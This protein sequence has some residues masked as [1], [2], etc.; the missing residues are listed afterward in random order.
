MGLRELIINNRFLKDVLT[1]LS[2]SAIAQI[3]GF[4]LMPVLT[5][6]FTPEEFGIFYIFLTTASILSVLITG[7]YE[8]SLVL[9]PSDIDAR[10]LLSFVFMLS[11]LST[12]L[13]LIILLFLQDWGSVFFQTSHSKLILWLI[14]V[15]AF[16]FGIF[17]ILQNWSI[18]RKKFNNVSGSNILRTGATSGIQTGFGFLHMGSIGLIIGSCISQIF[19]LWFLMSEEKKSFGKFNRETLK[20]AWLKGKEY[21][22]F[23]VYKMPS[24]LVNETSIQLPVYILKIIFSNAAAG[25]YS[26][27]Q[28]IM[29]QPSKIIG[30]AAGEVYYRRASEL[31]AKHEDLSEVTFNTF[32][33]L[34]L[35]GVLPF[36][37]IFLWGPEIF[38][39]IF[40]NEWEFSGRIAAY[41]SP[42]LLFVFSGSPVSYIFLIKQKLRL[43][44]ALNMSLLF[45]RLAALLAGSLIIKNLEITILLFAAV[46]F[47]YWVLIAFYSL[48]LS[49]IKLHRSL[50]FILIVLAISVLP[51]ALLKIFLL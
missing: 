28:K 51:L 2:G 27:P 17:R 35:L 5:R 4:A 14:P 23:P 32:K 47:V 46:S 48:Y 11:I 6:L 25:I 29:S 36:T 39:F 40:S 26:L 15:Y 10:K 21:K 38:S 16:L 42:W 33:V 37:I 8:K 3:I 31:N 22:D 20:S 50:L 41:L 19:P 12:V 45:I 30:Q 44:L 49:G 9:P 1:L 13:S 18:R 43:S 24:D 7:G 34:F